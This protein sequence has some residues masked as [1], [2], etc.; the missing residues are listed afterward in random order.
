LSPS[1]RFAA[2]ALSAVSRLK[3][4]VKQNEPLL[5]L[6]QRLRHALH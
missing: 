1:G 6:A 5:R 4:S 3:R 2:A